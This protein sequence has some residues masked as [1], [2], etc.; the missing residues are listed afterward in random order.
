MPTD[1]ARPVLTRRLAAV[2]FDM[3][4][5]LVDSEKIWQIGL[6]DLAAHVGGT[7]P[8]AVR[9]AMVG[10]TTPEAIALLHGAL[11]TPDRSVDADGTWLEDRV[12]ELF[13]EGLSWRPG[14]HELLTS[15]RSAGIPTALVTATARPL[16]EIMLR[17]I[18]RHNFDAIVT[19]NDVVRGKPH[20]EPYAAAAAALGADPSGCVAIEDSP[21]GIASAR[22]A[23][24]VVVAVPA[25]VDLSQLDGVAL[26]RSLAD[27]DVAFLESL[28][29]P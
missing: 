2:L 3:D 10:T 12:G 11:G 13:A 28:V 26:V 17:T 20:P 15:V 29:A 23:G 18:G 27:V 6:D 21:T 7:L 25:E 24:C 1:Y 19:D 14:A 5:T 4:G 8:I 16:V 22:A 9:K